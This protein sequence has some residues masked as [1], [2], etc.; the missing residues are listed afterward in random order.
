MMWPAIRYVLYALAFSLLA[1]VNVDPPNFW[2]W[3]ASFVATCF[4]A[5]SWAEGRTRRMLKKEGA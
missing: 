1:S 2:V 3:L 4:V 5:A